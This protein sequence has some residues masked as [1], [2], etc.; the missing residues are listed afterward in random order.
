[1]NDKLETLAKKIMAECE[2]DNEP[3]TYEEALEMA[4]MEIKSKKDCKQYVSDKTTKRTTT[5]ERKV[6]NDKKYLLDLLVKQFELEKI[7]ITNI[8][9][10]TELSFN[11]RG[12]Q[13]TFKLTKHKK[14]VDK[15]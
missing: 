12:N 15:K 3:V 6:D 14:G 7:S 13:Y 8:K 10:E 11:F 4:E 1:M 9:T 5:R 2:K